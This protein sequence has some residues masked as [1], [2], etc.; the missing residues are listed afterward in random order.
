MDR[1]PGYEPGGRGFDSSP[2]RHIR[3]SGHLICPDTLLNQGIPPLVKHLD[4]QLNKWVSNP[5]AGIFAG[6]AKKPEFPYPQL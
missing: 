3:I 5:K 2:A 4:I 6:I 1:V